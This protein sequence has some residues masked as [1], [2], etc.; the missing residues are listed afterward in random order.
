MVGGC[1]AGSSSML[2]ISAGPFCI[3]LFVCAFLFPVDCEVSSPLSIPSSP[4]LPDS[5]LQYPEVLL[6]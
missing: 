4:P 1:F 2:M 3:L 6:Q 5:R